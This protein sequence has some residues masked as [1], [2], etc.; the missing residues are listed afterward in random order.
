[1]KVEWSQLEMGLH[2]FMVLWFEGPRETQNT[3]GLE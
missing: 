1:M 2:V 3:S